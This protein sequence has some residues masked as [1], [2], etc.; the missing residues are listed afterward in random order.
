MTNDNDASSATEYENE[1]DVSKYGTLSIK[2]FSEGQVRF[3]FYSS[4]YEEWDGTPESLLTL[5]NE[6]PPLTWEVHSLYTDAREKLENCDSMSEEPE[7]GVEDWI[8]G[9][10]ESEFKKLE[11]TIDRWFNEAPAW[12]DE[13]DYFPKGSTAQSA[14]MEFFEY[15]TSN[16]RKILGV[17]IVE[18]EHP[19]SSYYAA[20]LTKS[21][22]ATNQ[23][24]REA[25]M[26]IR[27]VKSD[28][29]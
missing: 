27:F 24:A 13:S 7:D 26:S 12:K 19:G 3:D 9:M 17:K 22:E 4:E 14:A 2:G 11:V 1:F 15:L 29:Y 8:S 5:M 23:A 10:S 20:E 25:G 6:C 21:V 18:G 16:E 28:S